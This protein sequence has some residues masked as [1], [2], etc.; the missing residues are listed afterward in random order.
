MATIIDMDSAFSFDRGGKQSITDDFMYGS[1]VA[2]AHVY[3]R[4]G[5][6]R[7]VYGILCAQLLATTIVAAICKFTPAVSSFVAANPWTLTVGLLLTLVLLVGLHVYR[8]HTPYNYIFLSAFTLVEA[9]SLGIVVTYYDQVIVLEAF[10]LTFLIT[11]GLTAYTFQSKKDFSG[12]GAA[13]FVSLSI[14]FICGIIQVFV[15][16]TFLELVIA[17]AGSLLFSLF[18]IFDTQ[19]IMNHVSPEEYILAAINLYLDIFNLFLH[20]LRLLDAMKRS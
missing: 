17:G 9:Y 13:L 2:Q 1:N 6:L 19:A 7:K 8:R 11:L 12:W 18:I 15:G 3:I 5:F 16:S 20:L 10:I 14:L 4:M